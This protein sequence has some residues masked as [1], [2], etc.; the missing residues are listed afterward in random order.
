MHIA[1]ATG[2]GIPNYQLQRYFKDFL[3]KNELNPDRAALL[4]SILTDAYFRGLRSKEIHDPDPAKIDD[5]GFAINGSG[6]P[7]AATGPGGQPG[8]GPGRPPMGGS[9]LGPPNRPGPGMPNPGGVGGNLPVKDQ[10]DPNTVHRKMRE[11]LAIKSQAT[12]WALYYYL[13]KARPAEFRNYL[14]ELASMPR[15]IPLEGAAL[16]AFYRAFNLDGSKE[17]LDKFAGIWLDYIHNIAPAG[18]DIL[19]HEPKPVKTP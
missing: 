7:P 5:K 2:Y 14:N 18:L 13:A 9:T 10:E 16:Q 11:R 17:S 3:N 4:K 12:S 19:I 6:P 15:D 8:P 1:D